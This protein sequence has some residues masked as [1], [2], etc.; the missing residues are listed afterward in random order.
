MIRAVVENG[1]VFESTGPENLDQAF[2]FEQSCRGLE[3]SPFV[4]SSAE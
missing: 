3:G 2:V 1:L 4:E